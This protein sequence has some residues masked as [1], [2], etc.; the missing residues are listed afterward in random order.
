LHSYFKIVVLDK[1]AKVGDPLAYFATINQGIVS[2]ADKFSDAHRRK[3]SQ[4][5]ATKGE[6]IFVFPKGELC[7]IF[8]DQDI[9]KPWFKNSDISRW[10]TSS[11]SDKELIYADGMMPL[12]KSIVDYLEKFKPILVARR[13]FKDGKR[14]W[15][16]LHWPRDRKIFDGEKIIVPQRSCLNTFAYNQIPW[17][18]SADV[19]FITP[20][21][22]VRFEPK[23]LLGILNSRL[24]Y[25]WLYNRGKRK[26]E[27]LELYGTPL[28]EIPIVPATDEQKKGISCL[29]NQIISLKENNIHADTQSLEIEIDK[30]IYEL[31]DLTKDEIAIIE[32]I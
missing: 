4:V 12:P 20:R 27:M 30:L 2:G 11:F 9:I 29:V 26:G 1:V 14:P 28:S 31:Y 16:E 8:D 22:G 32:A 10:A 7:K 23:S 17:Y 21:E 19:Y 15:Y 13:E 24:I 25:T 6:G 3:F 18:A 5:Q